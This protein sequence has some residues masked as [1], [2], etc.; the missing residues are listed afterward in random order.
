MNGLTT[1]ILWKGHLGINMKLT[2]DDTTEGKMIREVLRGMHFS[3]RMISRLKF[4]GGILV[5]GQEKTVRY[6]LIKGDVLELIFPEKTEGNLQR[7]EMPLDIVY[8]D[9]TILVLNKPAEMASHPSG[10]HEKDTLANAVAGYFERTGFRASVRMLGRLDRNTSGLMLIS[11]NAYVHRLLALQMQE[12]TYQ[13][14]YLAVAH[15]VCP[16]T[17]VIDAPIG[18]CMGSIIQRC[19]RPDGKEAVTHFETIRTNAEYSLVELRPKTGRTHQIRIHMQHIGHSLAGDDFYGGSRQ[20]I[21]RHALHA[22]KIAF[23]HPTTGKSMQ[24]CRDIPPDM[25]ALME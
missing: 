10:G 12:G 4:N 7:Q 5:N 9:E 25:A 18:L 19:V 20:H 3:V 17:G 24:F 21:N 15:G 8:E 23:V 11:K 13:K 16:P 14:T 2:V 1:M 22:H 6:T